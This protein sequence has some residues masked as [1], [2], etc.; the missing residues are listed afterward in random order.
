V[1]KAFPEFDE[2]EIIRLVNTKSL[3]F[4]CLNA[5]ILDPKNYNV[6]W[7]K[8]SDGEKCPVYENGKPLVKRNIPIKNGFISMFTTI[9][10]YKRLKIGDAIGTS[11]YNDL[12]FNKEAVAKWISPVKN[13][14]IKI[15][16]EKAKFVF[17]TNL[18]ANPELP[19]YGG[20][21]TSCFKPIFAIK[22][23]TKAA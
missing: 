9:G 10:N 15:K 21:D 22:P 2:E 8:N 12:R 23:K 20:I 5:E 7:G 18:I 6:F 17:F 11:K 19:Y 13:G 16:T 1:L 4:P 14:K 3:N